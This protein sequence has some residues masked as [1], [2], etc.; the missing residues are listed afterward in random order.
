M[1]TP[2]PRYSLRLASGCLFAALGLLSGCAPDKDHAV[3]SATEA[4]CRKAEACD[5]TDD[6]P[7]CEDATEEVFEGLWA[8]DDCEEDGID[9]GGWQDCMEAID[10]LNCEDWT[11]GLSSLGA[12]DASDVCL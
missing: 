6:V 4:Y 1:R 12:C 5:W 7:E 11:R 9:Y 8:D 3:E 2:Q 10:N